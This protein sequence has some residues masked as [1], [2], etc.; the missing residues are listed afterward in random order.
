MG[1]KEVA[2][3]L[4]ALDSDV[5]LFVTSGY[6]EAPV[7]AD[8]AAHGFQASLRKPFARAELAE[9]FEGHVRRS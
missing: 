3:A 2:L 4:R 7:M 9:L 6:A 5:P 1:G 8:P